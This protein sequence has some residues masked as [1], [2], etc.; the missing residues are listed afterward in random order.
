MTGVV[1][2][3]FEFYRM[4]T[5]ETWFFAWNVK[6]KHFV[7]KKAFWSPASLLQ[8]FLKFRR[9]VSEIFLISSLRYFMHYGMIWDVL[10]VYTLSSKVY[11]VLYFYLKKAFKLN[12]SFWD[13]K[14]FQNIF[15]KCFMTPVKKKKKWEEL[16]NFLVT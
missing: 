12:F 6:Y 16:K 2:H 10:R 1:P 14:N 4:L 5:R 9:K 13:W 11:F 8:I 15:N 3:I 7:R